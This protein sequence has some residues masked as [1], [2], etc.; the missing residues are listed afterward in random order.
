MEILVLTYILI[1][2]I[3][4]SLFKEGDFFNAITEYKRELYFAAS[5]SN[6]LLRKIAISYLK[7]GMF[8]EAANYYSDILYE[9]PSNDVQMLFTICLI[10][11]KKYD[12]AQIVIGDF[13]DSLGRILFSIA[14]ALGGNYSEAFHILDSL[15][16][17]H[18]KYLSL[19]KLTTLTKIVP[20]LG[21]VF[22]GDFPLFIGTLALSGFGAYLIYYYLKRG[23]VYE[24]ILS[25]YPII[26]RFYGGG[27]RNTKVKYRLYYDNFF[28]SLLKQLESELIRREEAFIFNQ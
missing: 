16:V 23:L 22:L 13:T 11:L 20:G 27:I 4:D 9:N 17:E 26:E 5:D 14:S 19:N 21:L 3:G 28:K 8:E 18:P 6:L 10:N 24:A 25:G 12:E 15:R 1:T 2:S 7:R